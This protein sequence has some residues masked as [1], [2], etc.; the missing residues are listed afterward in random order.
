MFLSILGIIIIVAGFVLAKTDSPVKPYSGIIRIV[1]FLLVLIGAGLS[2]VKQIEPGY[3]GVQKLFGKVS[4]NTL[5][6]AGAVQTSCC[7]HLIGTRMI[8]FGGRI[9][10]GF[11]AGATVDTGNGCRSTTFPDECL[12]RDETLALDAFRLI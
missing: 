10:A 12:R 9:L 7:C 3:V 6:S 1:G 11:P 8:R 5:E 4:N 2:A